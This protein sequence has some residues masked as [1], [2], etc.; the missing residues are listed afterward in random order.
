P[1]RKDWV[2]HEQDTGGVATA[3][4]IETSGI[5]RDAQRRA[6]DEGRDAG[7]LPVVKDAADD[8]GIPQMARPRDIPQP[9]ELEGMSAVVAGQTIAVRLKRCVL[10]D[11]GGGRVAVIG[12]S[13]PG[14]V[15]AET[16]AAR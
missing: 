2:A 6:A 3:S 1:S 8:R 15:G 10:R 5:Q 14:V 9:V 12:D 13:G 7:K 11:G 16:E 4:D